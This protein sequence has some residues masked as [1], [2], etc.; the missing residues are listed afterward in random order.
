MVTLMKG[1]LLRDFDKA[2]VHLLK[3]MALA[4]KET[5]QRMSVTAKGL[6]MP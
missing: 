4:M 5:G 3:P 6:T 2:K 1:L